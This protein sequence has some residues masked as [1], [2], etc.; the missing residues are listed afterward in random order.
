MPIPTKGFDTPS[1]AH[2]GS[3]SAGGHHR[4]PTDPSDEALSTS[5]SR[6]LVSGYI[7]G[8]PPSPVR[9]QHASVNGLLEADEDVH[10]HPTP[11]LSELQGRD[12]PPL[13]EFTAPSSPSDPSAAMGK[14]RIA[15]D[16]PPDTAVP[17][18]VPGQ[19][20]ESSLRRNDAT[21][22]ALTGLNDGEADLDESAPQ[23]AFTT[24][25]YLQGD[26]GEAGKYRFPRHRLR[27]TMKDETKIP[28]VIGE[29][30]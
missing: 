8:N 13:S 9:G 11:P 15:P 28:L 21:Y 29:L 20:P 19:Q 3:G 16:Q 18:V 26:D 5:R 4:I 12:S 14:M 2:R 6:R 1:I 7:F 17:E 10:R 23:A 27:K 30:I 24:T 25:E 22:D